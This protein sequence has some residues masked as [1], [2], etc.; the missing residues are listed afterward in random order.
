MD[1]TLKSDHSLESGLLFDFGLNSVR[2][3][4]INM[5]ERKLSTVSLRTN[6]IMVWSKPAKMQLVLFVD[7]TVVQ[8]F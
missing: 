3:E 1:R 7:H 8:L 5:P 2:G 4:K 6:S